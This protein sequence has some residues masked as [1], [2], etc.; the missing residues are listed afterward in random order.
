[1]RRQ[2]NP[3]VEKIDQCL[4]RLEAHIN[5]ACGTAHQI[6]Y[7][8]LYRAPTGFRLTPIKSSGN[9]QAYSATDKTFGTSGSKFSY[10]N[11]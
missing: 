3:A 10:P 7:L 11:L 9:P 2:L 6:N 1:M 5:P 4:Q 8:N